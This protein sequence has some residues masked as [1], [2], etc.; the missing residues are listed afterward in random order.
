MSLLIFE[1]IFTVQIDNSQGGSNLWAWPHW[2]RLCCLNMPTAAHFRII[3]EVHN[4][5][6]KWCSCNPFKKVYIFWR[7]VVS[8]C[9]LCKFYPFLVFWRSIWEVPT[10]CG[11]DAGKVLWRAK[12][13]GPGWA[14]LSLTGLRFAPDFGKTKLSPK[15]GWSL[16]GR[17]IFLYIEYDEYAD[18][19]DLFCPR[20]LW[21]VGLQ[22]IILWWI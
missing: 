18:I 3:L 16:V 9:F 5:I 10:P 20:I 22:S 15:N 19:H 8:A 11:C 6:F 12:Q 4:M 21:G 2:L 14:M 1:Q 7:L 13:N 17:G